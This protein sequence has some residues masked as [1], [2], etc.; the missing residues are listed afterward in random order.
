M[1]ELRTAMV[2][3]LLQPHPSFLLLKDA[4]VC[5]TFDTY[6]AARLNRCTPTQRAT[7]WP[8][9]GAEVT[10]EIGGRDARRLL[11]QLDGADHRDPQDPLAAF[12]TA[13]L[14]RV[15][16]MQGFAALGPVLGGDDLGRR[17]EQAKVGGNGQPVPPPR[18]PP[19]PWLPPLPRISHPRVLDAG[20]DPRDQ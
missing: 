19:H 10:R 9:I 7:L 18:R 2:A 16:L 17:I 1:R 12:V 8:R 5:F 3:C 14:T 11:E 20:D 4:K 15:P 6:A 13:G